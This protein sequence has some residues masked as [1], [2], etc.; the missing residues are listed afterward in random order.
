MTHAPASSARFDLPV[1]AEMMVEST[2][3]TVPLS[4]IKPRG[5]LPREGPAGTRQVSR[6]LLRA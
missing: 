1:I 2:P 5:A 6:V 4:S 3:T